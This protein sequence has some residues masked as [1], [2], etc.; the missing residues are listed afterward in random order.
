MATISTLTFAEKV[1][2]PFCTLVPIG[3]GIA[4][5]FIW[6]RDKR[7]DDEA[8]TERMAM[9]FVA[10]C[11]IIVGLCV[12]HV[13][14]NLMFSAADYRIGVG[15]LGL[16]FIVFMCIAIHGGVLKFKDDADLLLNARHERSD[17]ILLTNDAVAEHGPAINESKSIHL[18][19]R[20]I[21]ALTYMMIVFQSGFD[22]LVLKYNPNAQNSPV[23]VSMFFLSKLLES[24]VVSSALIHAA[25]RTKW[26][27]LY[28]FN[29]TVTVGLSTLAAY[30]L[31]SPLVI[32]VVFEHWALQA[33]LGAS[34]GIL[35]TLS[36]YYI[37]L[38]SQRADYIKTR[39]WISSIT[40][41]LAFSATALTGMF[42]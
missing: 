18:R 4:G 39:P 15:A 30:E 12:F 40:F 26:Y 14:R 33:A 41:A 5:Y 1:L 29:F 20:Y 35:L 13:I 31:V 8:M 36:Y 3:T 16:S 7:R 32:A 23:Q 25:V 6:K 34:G 10:D 22:G 38:E 2:L 9:W 37:H 24:I 21:T 19:R 28:M 17:F 27:V 42:G 11:A